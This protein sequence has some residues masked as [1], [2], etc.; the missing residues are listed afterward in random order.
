MGVRGAIGIKDNVTAVLHSV[1]KEQSSF[2][3]DVISTRKTLEKTYDKKRKIK[4]ETAPATKAVKKLLNKTKPLRKKM[5]TAVALKDMTKAKIQKTKARLK[6]LGKM[7]VKPIVK[8]KNK[9]GSGIGKIKGMLGSLLK[10]IAVPV[11]V[12]VV[13]GVAGLTKAVQGG[14]KLE[15]QQM[16]IEH[17]VGA[18]N[19]DMDKSQVKAVSESFMKDL[20]NNANATPFETGEVIQAGS[21]AIAVASGNTKE[22]MGLVKLAEDM[23][24][25]SGGTKSVSDAIEALADAKLGET[26]RL[27]EFGFKVSAEEFDKKGF[28]GVASDLSEFYGGASEKLSHS[29]AGILSTI[30]GK[31]KSNFDDF[32]LK[33]VDKL[34][35]VFSDVV[36][37]I[38]KSA[39]FFEE[40]GTKMA[41]GIGSGIKTVIAFIPRLK[42]FFNTFKP[43][44]MNM[45]NAVVPVVNSIMQTLGVVIPAVIPIV[46]SV[47]NTVMNVIQSASPIITEMVG[48]IGGAISTLAPVFQ[49][50]FDSIGEKVGV[51]IDFVASKMGFVH[52]VFD[53]VVPLISEVLTTA[54]SIIEPIMDLMI[55]VFKAVWKVVEFVFPAIKGIITTVW[56]VLKPIFDAIADAMTWVGEAVES[57]IGW[58]G[59]VFSG[60]FDSP[61]E[62]A[63]K[64]SDGGAGKNALG[65]DN[66]KG[67]LTWVG[68]KGAE[69]VDLPKGSRILPNKTSARLME[70]D[71]GFRMPQVKTTRSETKTSQIIKVELAKLADSIVVREEADIDK[72]GEKIAEQ[73]KMAKLVT[74]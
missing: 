59:D 52:E 40:F 27:K 29:G 64:S 38:D 30:K 49:T 74:A 21:R 3:K 11:T 54:W 68:E 37:L 10:G 55:T 71:K 72:I 39:P 33:V 2:R 9:V 73:I 35:P 42:T 47:A 67:G 50:I 41:D 56:G 24:A 25:A 16:S 13:G 1:K 6:A 19:K 36:D 60:V 14:M 51:V 5:V 53:F 7:S 65:T 70:R 34:K 18:T 43:I 46:Q 26:E 31:L 45:Y 44:A 8:L 48:I 69:L 63:V 66:W 28:K 62:G 57:V 15:Q 20:R 58:F 32:G 61:A 17:F 22:A 4:I 23:A 12:A